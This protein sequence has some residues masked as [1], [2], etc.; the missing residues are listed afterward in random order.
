[1]ILPTKLGRF[2]WGEGGLRKRGKNTSHVECWGMI[3]D[4]EIST[5][6]ITS[7]LEQKELAT[8]VADSK[9]HEKYRGIF[10]PTF[11]PEIL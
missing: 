4:K 3:L 5:N 9:T 7:K 6:V 8:C 2:F 11:S 10:E 1:M